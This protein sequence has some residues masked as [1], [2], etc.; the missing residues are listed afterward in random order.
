MYRNSG[1]DS[2]TN[3]RKAILED[4]NG[5]LNGKSKTNYFSHG[6]YADQVE[7][8]T[9]HFPEENI[10]VLLFEDLVKNPKTSVLGI[11]N[12][13]GLTEPEDMKYDL[14][15]N[16]TQDRNLVGLAKIINIIAHKIPQ[17][18]SKRISKKAENMVRVLLRKKMSGNKGPMKHEKDLDL[19]AEFMKLYIED[20]HKLE[21]VIGR[22]LSIWINKYN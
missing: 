3:A 16:K 11:F 20:I 17:G 8:F 18:I 22:D 15:V 2:E 13:L 6:L 1:L 4:Y 10:H 14:W 21:K 12:F 7:F 19:C 5:F 9:K